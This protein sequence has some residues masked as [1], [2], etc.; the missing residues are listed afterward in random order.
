MHHCNWEVLYTHTHASTHIMF[1][2]LS[3]EIF[4]SFSFCL[5][6]HVFSLCI[7]FAGVCF[8][9]LGSGT[10]HFKSSHSGFKYV[11]L[12]NTDVCITTAVSI[13]QTCPQ[14]MISQGIL[15]YWHFQKE[16]AFLTLRSNVSSV[17]VTT[18]SEDEIPLVASG[19][20][21]RQVN[22]KWNF[23]TDTY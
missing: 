5:I 6:A 1:V 23:H 17:P 9:Q 16:V 3:V 18:R 15:H 8:L 13:I 14:C 11:K 22:D 2:F 19:E 7:S 21:W 10:R 4:I 20:Q 12:W